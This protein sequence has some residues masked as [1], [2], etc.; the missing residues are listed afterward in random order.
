[1]N[2]D[3]VREL[4]LNSSGDAL[5]E[6]HLAECETCRRFA[7]LQRSLDTRLTAALGAPQLSPQFRSA[8]REQLRSHSAQDGWSESLPDFAHL[9]G[10]ALGTACLAAMLPKYS[11]AILPAAAAFTAV[12][13]FL[14]AVLRSF[15]QAPE[16]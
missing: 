5:L 14:Q 1:M 16:P 4:L 6:A 12:T 2:C 11:N 3:E 9:V 15:L 8:L 13:Y 7:A 10:C